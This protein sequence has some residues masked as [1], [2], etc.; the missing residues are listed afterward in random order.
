MP[1]PSPTILIVETKAGDPPM[2]FLGPSSD[3]VY[4]FSM[5]HGERYG[6]RHDLSRAGFVLKRKLRVNISPL[7]NFGD[8]RADS[9]EERDLLERLWQDA[10][11]V[12]EA[13]RSAAEAIRE[14]AELHDLTEEFP[15]LADRLDELAEM[16]SWAAAQGAQVRL[17]YVL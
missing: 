2:E 6:A 1:D 10:A 17:T 4:F 16:A 7:L 8:A 5:A 11:P 3:L 12:A 13:A 9:S 15:E 14:T